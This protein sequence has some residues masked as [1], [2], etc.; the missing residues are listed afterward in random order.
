VYF[1][2]AKTCDVLSFSSRW[3]PRN[4]PK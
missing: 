4:N 1:S 3:G 2:R